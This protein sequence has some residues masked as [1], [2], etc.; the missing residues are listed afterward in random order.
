MDSRSKHILLTSLLLC[1][2][3]ASW[4][5][6]TSTS[7]PSPLTR[8]ASNKHVFRAPKSNVWSELSEGEASQVYD[9]VSHAFSDLNLVTRPKSGRDNFIYIVESLRPNKTDAVPYL[10]AGE[11]AP[12]RWAKL[13][14]AENIDGEPY[15]VYY[16]VGPLPISSESKI[17]PLEYTFNSG[18]NKVRNPVRD[19]DAL[20]AFGI[21]IGHIISDITKDLLGATTD[22]GDEDGILCLPRL[23]R[24]TGEG[25]ILW[26][27][28]FRNGFG[29]GGRTLLPQGIYAKVDATSPSQSDWTIKGFYY[30]GIV[31]NDVDK[32]RAALKDPLFKRTPPNLDGDWTETEDFDAAPEGRDLPPP[33]TVQPYGSRYR[34]DRKE[35][36]VSWFGFEFYVTS[37]QATGLSLF[38][39]RFKGERV[40]YEL[41]LQEAMAHYAGDDPMAGGQEFLDTFFG[42]GKSMF[43]LLPGKCRTFDLLSL[44]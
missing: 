18:R 40:L 15:L 16:A 24:P 19:F 23:T 8:S 13:V 39:I 20:N 34:L 4:Y 27:Q 3:I 25:L 38:D 10:Y 33:V 28:F 5:S 31:Y 32:F 9:F 14:L 30:N 43:E 17:L 37:A 42:M 11:A 36:F 26:F 12:Q 35:K 6:L 44:C 7:S 1:F 2:A 41:G 21:K 22:N 29:S